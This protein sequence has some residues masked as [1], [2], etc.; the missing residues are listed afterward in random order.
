V[1]LCIYVLVRVCRQP[2]IT[3]S[4]VYMTMGPLPLIGQAWAWDR[5]TALCVLVAPSTSPAMEDH[6][7]AAQVGDGSCGCLAW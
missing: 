6:H 5:T 2:W 3:S 7:G 1:T 4:Y